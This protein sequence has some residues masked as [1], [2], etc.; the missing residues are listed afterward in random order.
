MDNHLVLGVLILALEIFFA[1]IALIVMELLPVQLAFSIAVFAMILTLV[2]PIKEFYHSIDCPVIV[3]LGAMI[4]VGNALETSEGAR[5]ITQ[6]LSELF[7]K[8]P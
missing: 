5:I 3:L 4:P 8:S 2:L 6:T 7:Q 1:T